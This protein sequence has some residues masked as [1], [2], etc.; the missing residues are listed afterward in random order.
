MLTK[1]IPQNIQEKLK[2]KERALERAKKPA[3]PLEG[4]MSFKSMASRTIFVRMCSNKVNSEDNRMID[5]GF[6]NHFERK[7]F[8]F[9]SIYKNSELVD[10]DKFGRTWILKSVVINL[11]RDQSLV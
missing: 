7:P 3:N 6:N 11:V 4:Y 9:Y 8:G 1:Y 10:G 5:G 2:A